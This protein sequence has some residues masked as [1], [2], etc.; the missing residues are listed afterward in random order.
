[1]K[2]IKTDLELENKES[3]KCLKEIA[4]CNN[5]L[6]GTLK[7]TYTVNKNLKSNYNHKRIY[8][9]MCVNDLQSAFRKEKRYRWKRS[10]PEVTVKNSLNRNFEVTQPNEVWC[11]DI[12]EI[13]YP[14]IFPK[15]YMSSYYD[16]YNRGITGLSVSKKMI[17]D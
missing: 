13:S 7:M 9:L 15:A 4:E 1:M 12:T 5:H 16:L 11:T 6:F 17:H 10:T 2:R 14:G 8:R 3:V